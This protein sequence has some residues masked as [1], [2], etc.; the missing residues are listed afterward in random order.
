MNV[1]DGIHRLNKKEI[2]TLYLICQ[3]LTNKEIAETMHVDAKTIATRITRINEKLKI[4]GENQ[5]KRLNL[6][7]EYCPAVRELTLD[8]LKNWIPQEPPLDIR[9]KFEII[10]KKF[11][12]PKEPSEKSA[13]NWNLL[14]GGEPPSSPSGE[15]V[16]LITQDEL[17]KRESRIFII[18]GLVTIIL[19]G[20]II[21]LLR[22][23]PP[24]IAL[25]SS[26]RTPEY[27]KTS[28]STP[29]NTLIPTSSDLYPLNNITTQTET[30]EPTSTITPTPTFTPTLTAPPPGTVLFEDKFDNGLSKQ[31]EILN[32]DPEISKGH[33]TANGRTWLAVGDV[34]WKNIQIEFTD[35]NPSYCGGDAQTPPLIGVRATD[36]YNFVAFHFGY[37]Y[38]DVYKVINNEYIDIPN[39]EGAHLG[40][41]TWQKVKVVVDTNTF[42]IFL[43]GQ[44]STSYTSDQ[45]SNGRVVLSLDEYTSI[46]DFKIT[47]LP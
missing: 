24:E 16:F 47:S 27:I 36:W 17:K 9:E 45:F 46:D 42:S 8:D 11:P 25:I 19:V 14:P 38:K 32:G 33:L 39:S 3:G 13:E 1:T 28:N 29:E 2:S 20:I 21:F 41:Q 44:P 31:W 34:G 4:E 23:T 10:E 40:S 37:C 7:S 5:N 12:E 22:R 18:F 26:T 35:L 6:Q 30:L 43:D 15:T